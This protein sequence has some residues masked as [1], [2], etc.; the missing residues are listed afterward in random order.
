MFA[1]GCLTSTSIWD[2]SLFTDVVDIYDAATDAWSTAQLSAPRNVLTATAVG[3]YAIFAGGGYSRGVNDVDIY[4]SLDGTWSTS[5]LSEGR[6]WLAS[7]TVGDQ[8]IIGG[9]KDSA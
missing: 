4:N 3:H 7:T 9:G 6:S 1:G 2:D 8:A 5:T